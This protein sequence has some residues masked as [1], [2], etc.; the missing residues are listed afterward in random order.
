[1]SCPRTRPG[2]RGRPAARMRPGRERRGG[3][4]RVILQV[5]RARLLNP[6]QPV[7]AQ[8][9]RASNRSDQ[10]ADDGQDRVRLGAET[11]GRG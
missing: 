3:K 11:Q 6:G 9:A 7:G 2:L 8:E 5:Q 1:M 4:A 10:R